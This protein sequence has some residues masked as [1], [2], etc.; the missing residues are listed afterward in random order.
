MKT[1]IRTLLFVAL[2]IYATQYLIGAFSYSQDR[3]IWLSIL[4]L[5]ILYLFLRPILSVVSLPTR[6]SVYVLISSICTGLVFYALVSIL[7]D[8]SFIPVTLESLNIFSVV[9]PSRDLSSLWAMIFSSLTTSIIYLFLE[10]LC[11]KK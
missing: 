11:R 3:T 2:S 9:L 7:P 6:G 1:I 8:F 5:V 10:S 4:A